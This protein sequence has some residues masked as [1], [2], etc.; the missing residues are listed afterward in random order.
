MFLV[1]FFFWRKPEVNCDGM[2]WQ[3]VWQKFSIT[4]ILMAEEMQI[5]RSF[6]WEFEF[7]SHSPYF[8]WSQKSQT[9]DFKH[10]VFSRF[11]SKC[12]HQDVTHSLVGEK[13]EVFPTGCIQVAGLTWMNAIWKV[14]ED[15]SWKSPFGKGVWFV[16]RCWC[17][18][19]TWHPPT[20]LKGGWVDQLCEKRILNGI[21][22][23]NKMLGMIRLNHWVVPASNIS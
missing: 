5:L 6:P 8:C 17:W 19:T 1:D 18:P 16:Q 7:S 9:Y 22:I 23:F 21:G 10:L 3:H 14:V 2:W 11:F 15:I 12:I 13:L 20:L 4:D